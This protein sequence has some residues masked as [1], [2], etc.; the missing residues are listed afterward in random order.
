MKFATQRQLPLTFSP[1]SSV[2]VEASAPRTVRWQSRVP[3]QNGGARGVIQ[4]TTH[5][6]SSQPHNHAVPNTAAATSA[7]A[8]ISAGNRTEGRPVSSGRAFGR[9]RLLR[10]VE[11]FGSCMMIAAFLV[12]ALFG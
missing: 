3:Q 11:V 8:G 12:L 5:A 6:R 4:L 1:R 9:A 7:M 10:A 2:A